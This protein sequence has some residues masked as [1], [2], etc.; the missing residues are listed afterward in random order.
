MLAIGLGLG[1]AAISAFIA[2]RAEDGSTHPDGF[3]FIGPEAGWQACRH[4]GEGRMSEPEAILEAI[5][6]RVASL[7]E[8]A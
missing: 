1:F 8:G 3:E 5:R 6:R 7:R 2:I 4:V